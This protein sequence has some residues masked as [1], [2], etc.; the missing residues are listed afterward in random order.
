MGSWRCWS[1]FSLSFPFHSVLQE[2]SIIMLPSYI[3]CVFLSATL[4]NATDFASWICSLRQQPCHVV[5]TDVRPTPLLHYIY[6]LGEKIRFAMSFAVTISNLFFAPRDGS[7]F[8]TW[9]A[10]SHMNEMKFSVVSSERDVSGCSGAGP[11][12]SPEIK[13]T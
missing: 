4:S 3:T 13:C 7:V 10:R 2:E 1:L 5:F 12:C 6:P 8:F 11:S 9:E